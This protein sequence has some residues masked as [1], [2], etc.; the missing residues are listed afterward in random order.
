MF[1]D[2]VGFEKNENLSTRNE[3]NCR[4]CNFDVYSSK[5]SIDPLTL[6][7]TKIFKKKMVGKKR[8]C[9]KKVLI[10][11]FFVENL[12]VSSNCKSLVSALNFVMVVFKTVLFIAQFGEK[13]S[14]EFAR[15]RT[16]YFRKKNGVFFLGLSV[17]GLTKK[18]MEKRKTR[19][20]EKV[21][22]EKKWGWKKKWIWGNKRNNHLSKP[23][24][25]SQI[26]VFSFVGKW[27]ELFRSFAVFCSVHKKISC[28]K[29]STGSIEKIDSGLMGLKTDGYIW[30]YTRDQNVMQ[31]LPIIESIP[32]NDKLIVKNKNKQTKLLRN[33]HS[34]YSSI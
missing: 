12:S 11:V 27:K 29:K 26:N 23:F 16:R 30:K 17:V 2:R 6:G 18:S 31:L 7:V 25:I 10:N 14:T 32:N 3:Y 22:G 9:W 1:V 33:A 20:K 24:V 13:S 21:L 19:W 34:L 5:F 4:K 28:G 15:Y 8:K